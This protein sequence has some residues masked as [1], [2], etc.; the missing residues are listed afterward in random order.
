[1]SKLEHRINIQLI[2]ENEVCTRKCGRVKFHRDTN[3]LKRL[4]NVP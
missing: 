3:L 4:K 1:M 2:F